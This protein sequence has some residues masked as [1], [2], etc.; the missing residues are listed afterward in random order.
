MY[1]TQHAAVVPDRPAIV[2]AGSGA[3]RS[4]RELD[5]N[6]ARLAAWLRR[7]GARTGDVVLVC[8]ENDVRWAEI[9]WACLRSGLYVAPVNWHLTAAELVPLLED[10]APVAVITSSHLLDAVDEAATKA[11][12]TS[13]RLVVRKP[14]FPQV[15]DSGG[16]VAD[17]DAALADTGPDPGVEDIAGSR[18]LFSSGTTGRPK[19]FRQPL[20][21]VH[22]SDVPVRLGPLLSRL[23]FDVEPGESLVYL[24]T[25]PAYHAAPFA[26]MQ[27]VH[28]LG[29]TV[30]MMER[31]DARESLT[32]IE[33]HRVT[34]SQWVPTMFVRLLRLDPEVRD[35][36]DLSTHRVAVHAGAP[37]PPEVKRA[38][39]DW[40]G[41]V[42]YEYYGASEG[43]GHT[44]IGPEEWLVHP[45]SVGRPVS[46]RVEI[47]DENGTALPAGETGRVWFVRNGAEGQ[48]GD[49]GSLDDDGFLHLTGRVGQTIITGGVNVYPREIEDVLAPH[50]AVR[51]VAVLGVP[52]AEFGEQV[53]AVVEPIDAASAGPELEQ[54][55]IEHC[56]A[57]LAHFKCPR[58]VDFTERLPRTETGKILAAPLRSAYW[59]APTERTTS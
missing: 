40:W 41:P 57:R 16:R 29:G 54:E 4:Y 8:L 17:Y 32:A 6:S 45:G 10:A 44:T 49:L 52:D 55:L 31:F 2:M 19:P 38:M 34:H 42:L 33:H 48:M 30:V 37:C 35:A 53:K 50:P 59:P 28:Q 5:D 26:F 9:I 36:F 58:S 27:T 24:S 15:Q 39:L 13:A 23:R 46:G 1:P 11:G 12:T 47:R 51:D 14:D 3:S 43:H 20:P 25:G 18:L 7:A 56:R 21:G 22:P